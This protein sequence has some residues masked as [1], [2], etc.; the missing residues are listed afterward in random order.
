MCA[1]SLSQKLETRGWESLTKPGVPREQVQWSRRENKGHMQP[2]KNSSSLAAHPTSSPSYS[3]PA[4]CCPPH[5][6]NWN[7]EPGHAWPR[8]EPVPNSPG[9]GRKL[10]PDLTAATATTLRAAVLLRRMSLSRSRVFLGVC[11]KA[12]EAF[13]RGHHAEVLIHR[14][15]KG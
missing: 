2:P 15:P 9:A 5:L 10:Q 4:R 8:R 3:R 7:R 1:R 14:P 11:T 12:H 6:A 13:S